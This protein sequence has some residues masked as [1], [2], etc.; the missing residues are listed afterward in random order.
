VARGSGSAAY[1]FCTVLC[2]PLHA[3]P[4]PGHDVSEGWYKMTFNCDELILFLFCS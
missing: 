3:A 1:P 2:V 4:R